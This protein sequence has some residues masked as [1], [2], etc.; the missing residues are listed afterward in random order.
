MKIVFVVRGAGHDQNEPLKVNEFT[1]QRTGPFPYL[2]ATMTDN[3][4]ED[5]K[6]NKG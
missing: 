1:F 4:M 6:Y 5:K 2:V 3:N